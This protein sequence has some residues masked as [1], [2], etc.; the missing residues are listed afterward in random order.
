MF[1]QLTWRRWAAWRGLH[2]FRR[3]CRT[4]GTTTSPSSLRW[5]PLTDGENAWRRRNGKVSQ[6]LFTRMGF[7]QLFSDGCRVCAHMS[8]L[9]GIELKSNRCNPL[10]A[11]STYIPETI[12]NCLHVLCRHCG[13]VLFFIL[14]LLAVLQ[15]TDC[16]SN[17]DT[18]WPSGVILILLFSELWGISGVQVTGWTSKEPLH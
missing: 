4:S 6:L 2:F 16:S 1:T 14:L 18:G 5:P 12:T 11:I 17:A 10:R 13:C 8:N 15:L 3:S 9:A 7:H